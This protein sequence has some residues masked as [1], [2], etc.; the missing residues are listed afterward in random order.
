MGNQTTTSAPAVE[1]QTTT[2]APAVENPCMFIAS[3]TGPL[4]LDLT[5]GE[6]S[7]GTMVR[8]RDCDAANP[9]A[10][11]VWQFKDG[12]LLHHTAGGVEL[13]L[14]IPNN[15]RTNGQLL[16][17]WTC[18]GTEQQQFEWAKGSIQ[19]GNGTQC[20]DLRTEDGRVQL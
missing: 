9:D 18:S 20:V 2:V 1:N 17:V 12:Q 11:Q 4:C 10:A 6:E 19:T 5:D 13:C 14:D 15:N 8:V 16:Q 7:D 3:S